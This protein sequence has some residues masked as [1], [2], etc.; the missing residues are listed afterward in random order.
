MKI[1]QSWSKIEHKFL[2]F[3]YH[4]M[5]NK[6]CIK[7]HANDFLATKTG[8]KILKLNFMINI[9]LRKHIIISE[10]LWFYF[11]CIY[12]CCF[13]SFESFSIFSIFD[14]YHF[15]PRLFTNKQK[16][17]KVKGNLKH[18]IHIILNQCIMY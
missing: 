4:E 1:G 10:Q 18:R 8:K 16:S 5:L 2:L 3:W 13:F 6:I 11:C 12:L 7:K 14:K 15:K 9:A 17:G